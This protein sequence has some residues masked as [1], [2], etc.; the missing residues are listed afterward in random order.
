MIAR[1]DFAPK[2]WNAVRTIACQR[3][4]GGPYD[5]VHVALGLIGAVLLGSGLQLRLWS[6]TSRLVLHA[7]AS[8]CERVPE[9]GLHPRS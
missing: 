7:N 1:R 3:I 2:S 4:R 8:V 9:W 5:I 6:R